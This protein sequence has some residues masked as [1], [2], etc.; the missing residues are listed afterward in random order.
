MKLEA[1]LYPEIPRLGDDKVKECTKIVYGQW[2]LVKSE[3][4]VKSPSPFPILT[5][6]TCSVK[7]LPGAVSQTHQIGLA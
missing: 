4:D 2:K 5:L 3:F 1:T 6:T 7:V